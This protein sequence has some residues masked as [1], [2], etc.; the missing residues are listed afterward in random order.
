[1]SQTALRIADDETPDH[2]R[3]LAL[4]IAD[5]RTRVAAGEI[6][7]LWTETAAKLRAYVF[8]LVKTPEGV[9]LCTATAAGEF[10]YRSSIVSALLHGYCSPEGYDRVRLESV[11]PVDGPERKRWRYTIE[12]ADP[13]ESDPVA[14]GLKP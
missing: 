7:A 1:M 9:A 8:N 6:S 12:V 2:A 4:L 5:I 14:S 10:L 11:G 13:I 3:E